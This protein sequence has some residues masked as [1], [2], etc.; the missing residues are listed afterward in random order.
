MA[1]TPLNELAVFVTV[2]R[3]GSFTRAAKELGVS[4]SAVSQTVRQLEERVGKALL[5]RTTRSVSLTDAGRRLH[6]QAA[7][8]VQTALAALENAAAR[9]TQVTGTLRLTVPAFAV[10][11]I[12]EPVL[13]RLLEL[14]PHV[15][16]DARVSNRFV[17]IASEG[18]DAGVRLRE[19]VAQDM[20]QLRLTPPFRFIIVASP[21]YVK[22][23][24][25][26][27]RPEDVT[28]HACIGYRTPSTGLPYHWE[29]ERGRRALR[30][31]VTGPMA[32]N[33]TRLNIAMA[34]AG[35]G[36]TY[37]AE[38]EAAPWLHSGALVPVLEDWAPTVP[39]LFLFY[40]HRTRI[41]RPLRAFIDVAKQVLPQ[42]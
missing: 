37:V 12:L 25:A 30:I 35:L 13:P 10:P 23:H 4:T 38:P 26:P 34:A 2:A 40:P 28:K 8:G 39:G 41:S 15:R 31:P 24:G 33:H 19:S 20:V 3:R 32:S 22:R 21:G 14:H 5:T 16:V 7:P 29:L 36:L 42:R 6:E 1:L 18:L 9:D 17:D 11:I 27:T